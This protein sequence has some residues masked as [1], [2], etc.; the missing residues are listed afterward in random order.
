MN[1]ATA[2]NRKYLEYTVVML[3]SL[4]FNNPQEKIKAYLLHHELKEEDIRMISDALAAYEVEVISMKVDEELFGEHI[5]RDT[6]WSIEIYYRLLLVEILPEEVERILYLDVDIIVNQS[7]QSL[8]EREFEQN[9]L[10]VCKDY[11]GRVP[12][13]GRPANW[14]KMFAPMF[15][16]GFKYFNSGVMLM[17]IGKMRDEYNFHTYMKAMEEWNYEM[18][19]PDQD[20]LNYVHWQSVIYEDDEKYDYFAA[21]AHESGI[22]YEMGKKKLCII[23]FSGPK[24]WGTKCYH[25]PIEQIWWDYAKKT[26]FYEFLMERFVQSTMS[27][28]YME[29]KIRDLAGEIVWLKEGLEKSISLNEELL[30]KLR[31]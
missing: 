16:R 25:Y 22:D 17:N 29:E 6:R 15:E 26:P 14:Q 30:G 9:D 13:G 4:C 23:H 7:I 21:I 2:L 11:N 8:Y 5:P 24:P 1:V 31:K 27:D 10:I 18:M 19:A 12:A 3:T 20:I 28:S